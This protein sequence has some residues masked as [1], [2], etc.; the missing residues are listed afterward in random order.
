M[1]V[2]VA[3]WGF[4]GWTGGGGRPPPPRDIAAPLNSIMTVSSTSQGPAWHGSG[5][6][7]P[8]SRSLTPFDGQNAEAA[9][10]K[11]KYI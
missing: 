2:C 6:K 8:Q 10:L 1:C 4:T 7:S 3:R 9:S 5:G 11:S